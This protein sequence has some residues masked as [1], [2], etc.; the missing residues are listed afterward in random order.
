MSHSV[1][2]AAVAVAAAIAVPASA[3]WMGRTIESA[4]EE[5]YRQVAELPYLKVV[6]RRYERGLFSATDT[7]TLELD[8]SWLKDMLSDEAAAGLS[9]ARD[10]RFT[11]R[12]DISHGPLPG[13][14]TFGAGEADVHL[15]L[16]DDTRQKVAKLFG[17]KPPVSAHVKFNFDGGGVASMTSPAFE[18]TE[19]DSAGAETVSWGGAHLILDF[20][21]NL[22]RYTMQFD[23]PRLEVRAPNGKLLFSDLS[24]SGEQY[25]P[26]DDNELFY[27]GTM[28]LTLDELHIQGLARGSF[29]PEANDSFT[30]G[31]LVYD[32]DMPMQGDFLDISARLG[33]QDFRVGAQNYGP[34]HYDVSLLRL[35]GRTVAGIYRDLMENYYDPSRQQAFANNPALL[36]EPLAEPMLSL[37]Q[38]NPELRLDRLSFNSPHGTASLSARARFNDLKPEDVNNPFALMFKLDASG[39]ISLPFD[40]LDQMQRMNAETNEEALLMSMNLSQQVDSLVG[41]GY[42]Q[43]EGKQLSSRIAFKDGQLTV[44]D[45]PFN[46]MA[47]GGL[48]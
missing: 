3:W 1:K 28:R 5:Q 23:L 8:K 38:H 7:V 41:Q 24:V 42:V 40:L 17:D 20:T 10:L 14:T 26:F 15:V 33:A 45:Q 12:T 13:W 22:G 11:L 36:F 16:D 37:L 4:Y 47:L 29:D 2:I 43:R 35:H 30:M 18:F 32:I 21:A 39:A 46:P 25:R 44:N 27:A 19:P 48:R 31:N 6:E 34:V 9:N